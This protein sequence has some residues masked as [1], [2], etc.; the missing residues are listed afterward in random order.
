VYGDGSPNQND[1]LA[2]MGAVM[3]N[4]G[5]AV[6]CGYT[7]LPSA[8]IRDHQVTDGV[9]SL[10]I[11]R[12]SMIEP[13]PEDFV[14][15]TRHHPDTGSGRCG[16]HRHHTDPVGCDVC[17]PAGADQGC[18]CRRHPAFSD[19]SVGNRSRIIRGGRG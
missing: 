5:D 17:K 18:A 10:R 1:F 4:I 11:A 9:N 12:A 3:R 13:G 8:S 6:D 7:T 2:R 19:R 16:T 15:F 14:L